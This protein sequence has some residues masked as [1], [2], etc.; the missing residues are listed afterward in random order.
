V[1]PVQESDGLENAGYLR[2]QVT[3]RQ[4]FATLARRSSEMEDCRLP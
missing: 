2:I 1:L 3:L 4:L